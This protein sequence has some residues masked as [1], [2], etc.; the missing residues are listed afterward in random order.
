MSEYAAY[1]TAYKDV[2]CLKK[3]LG[4]MG[5]KPSVIEEHE[6]PQQLYDY[7]GRPTHYL[8][9]N[10][11]KANIIVR[12]HNVGGAANDLGFVKTQDGTYSAIISAYDSGKH[13]ATWLNGL[14]KSYTEHTTMKT[15]KAQGLKFLGKKVVAGKVQLQFMKA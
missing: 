5:Y 13:S 15:A 12:R 11:D 6:V 3:A 14:K 7:C 10:G 9:K 4:D 8:D 1:K 2:D